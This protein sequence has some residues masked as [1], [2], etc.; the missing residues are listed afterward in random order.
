MK[1]MWIGS[2]KLRFVELDEKRDLVTEVIRERGAFDF[3]FPS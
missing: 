3:V 1:Y 2:A